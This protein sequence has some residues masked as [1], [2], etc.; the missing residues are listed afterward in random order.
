MGRPAE[1]PKAAEPLT[2]EQAAM[3]E[4]FVP[5]AYRL[6]YQYANRF[7]H[8]ADECLSHAMAAIV[9]ASRLYDPT[10]AK[11]TT[12]MWASIRGRLGHVF[13]KGELGLRVG[14]KSGARAKRVVMFSEM[15]RTPAYKREEFETPDYGPQAALARQALA[16]LDEDAREALRL[17][18]EGLTLK[19]IGDHFGVTKQCAAQR[20]QA[21]IKRVRAMLDIAGKGP[22]FPRAVERMKKPHPARQA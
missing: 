1:R 5:M 2:P 6:A 17:R 9:D 12:Y 10:K 15:Q 22:G 20:V 16:E 18:S 19:E 7:N 3:A 4:Q 13:A 14:P 21:A 11:A 8:D